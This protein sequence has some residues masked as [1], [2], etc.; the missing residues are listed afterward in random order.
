MITGAILLELHSPNRKQLLQIRQQNLRGRY[1]SECYKEAS[2][3]YGVEG[4]Q[5]GDVERRHSTGKG[6]QGECFHS[7]R[8]GCSIIDVQGWRGETGPKGYLQGSNIRVG[9]YEG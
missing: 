9:G 7:L 5:G 8:Q 3:N 6:G 4:Q 2:C 1:R